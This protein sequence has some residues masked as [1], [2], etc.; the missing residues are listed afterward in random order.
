MSELN[1]MTARTVPPLGQASQSQAPMVSCWTVAYVALAVVGMIMLTKQFTGPV[2]GPVIVG[3][4]SV[5][6]SRRTC[7]W[8]LKGH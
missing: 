1:V 6:V 4:L 8:G 7:D 3:L 2:V 5:A